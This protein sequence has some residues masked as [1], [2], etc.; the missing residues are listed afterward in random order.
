VKARVD[1]AGAKSPTPKKKSPKSN[2]KSK[3]KHKPAKATSHPV[4]VVEKDEDDVEIVFE[5]SDGEEAGA[6]ESAETAAE[7]A[8]T[9]TE[10]TEAAPAIHDGEAVA[11]VE[12]HL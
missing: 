4:A 2:G 10:S 9:A 11:A 6:T 7:R 3:R 5:E 12:S 8:E 1:D